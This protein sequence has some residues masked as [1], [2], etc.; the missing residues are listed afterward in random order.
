MINC[1]WETGSW[2]QYLAAP[3]LHPSRPSP[4]GVAWTFSLGSRRLHPGEH[5]HDPGKTE[6]S[7]DWI[8]R[9]G[10]GQETRLE[11]WRVLHFHSATLGCVEPF[12]LRK[13][14]KVIHNNLYFLLLMDGVDTPQVF[15]LG[16]FHSSTH[17]GPRLEREDW[18]LNFELM[19]YMLNQ[20]IAY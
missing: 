9:T 20:C 17:H 16:P 11:Q 8:G 2:P 13:P 12:L 14:E 3:H 15:R 18:G 7:E 1:C 19:V 5:R 4:P 10:V 6:S